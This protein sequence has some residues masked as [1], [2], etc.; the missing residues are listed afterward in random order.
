M[1]VKKD[2]M[3]ELRAQGMK[4]REIA[5]KFGVTKQYVACVCGTSESGKYIPVGD[6][7]VFPNLRRW[8]NENKVS[9]SEMLR[10]M[11]LEKHTNN[12]SRLCRCLRGEQ[13]PRKDYIDKLLAVTG[14]TYEVMFERLEA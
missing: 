14:M 4:F 1:S 8:M 6:E 13:Q 2:Q 9:R 3:R 7:C 11:G 12:M 5:E 10:R